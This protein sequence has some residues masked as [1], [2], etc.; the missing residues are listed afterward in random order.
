MAYNEY[1]K[2]YWLNKDGT[3]TYSAKASWKKDKKGW[4]YIDTKGWYAKKRWLK[5]DGSWYYFDEEG[6]MVTGLRTIGGKTYKFSDE[7]V[8]LNP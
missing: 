6:Y 1:C 2:G 8:C 7:G 3:C 4:Y 5:I